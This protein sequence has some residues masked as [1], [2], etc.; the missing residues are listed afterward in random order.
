[1][2]MMKKQKMMYP[3]GKKILA[4]K[5]NSTDINLS[6]F[7]AINELKAYI[8]DKSRLSFDGVKDMMKF[9]FNRN[10][11]GKYNDF[12]E[13]KIT[14]IIVTDYYTQKPID[15]KKAYYVVGSDVNGPMGEELIPF[16][17]LNSAKTFL[18]DHHG[19]KIIKFNEITPD[20]LK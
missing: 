5:C 3:M 2:V 7:S 16:T 8:K 10:K 12:M 11:Y 19:K 14:N 15:A 4:K 18:Q 9:Y 20:Y 6:K 1:M 17:S 13:D